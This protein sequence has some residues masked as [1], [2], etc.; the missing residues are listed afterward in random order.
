[1]RIS[2]KLIGGVSR[3]T[4]NASLLIAHVSR[5]VKEHSKYIEVDVKLFLND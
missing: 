1:M 3:T 2:N 4:G 5:L